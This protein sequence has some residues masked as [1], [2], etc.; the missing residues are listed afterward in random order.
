MAELN[1]SSRRQFV[2]CRRIVW[3]CLTSC[4]HYW[5][6]SPN[7]QWPTC[8]IEKAVLKNFVIFTG[9]HKNWLQHRCFPVNIANVYVHLFWRVYA[10]SCFCYHGNAPRHGKQNLNLHWTWVVTIMNQLELTNTAWP[11]VVLLE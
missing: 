5:R 7:R 3:V 10:N 11:V 6:F 8:S 9:K 2:L 4:S 1:Q